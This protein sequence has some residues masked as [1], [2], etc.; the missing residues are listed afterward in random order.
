MSRKQIE[1]PGLAAEQ[2]RLNRD[3]DAIK[4]Q[5]DKLLGD[6]EDVRLRG[7]VESEGGGLRFRV[8]DP[9]TMSVIPASPNRPL[10]LLGV[11][12]A[13]LV[14][15]IGAAFGLGQVRTTYATIGRLEKATGL[16]VIGGISDV[17]T[18]ARAEQN[19]RQTRWF[20]A[21]CG[22]LGALCFLLLAVE[23]IQR[24]MSA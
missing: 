23:F 9:P 11:L 7:D 22:G 13:G 19:R 3:Y 21:G 20:Y 24:G 2:D 6:R 5:Y 1:E 15:G 12:V 14:A 8:I 10:L 17:E 18:P 16:P 4:Q